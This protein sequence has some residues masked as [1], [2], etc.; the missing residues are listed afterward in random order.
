MNV[1]AAF[2]IFERMNRLD[3]SAL[4]VRG[5]QAA[6]RTPTADV[7]VRRSLWFEPTWLYREL[8]R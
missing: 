7:I 4:L 3:V 5:L 2:L 8:S 6:A 1:S